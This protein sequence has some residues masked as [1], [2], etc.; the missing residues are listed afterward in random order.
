MPG[1]GEHECGRGVAGAAGQ[2][3]PG[4]QH[5][6]LR[7]LEVAERRGLRGVEQLAGPVGRG[8]GELGVRG[9][10]GAGAGADAVEIGLPFSDPMLDGPVIQQALEQAIARGA[11]TESLV[12]RR[13]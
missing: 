12:M 1:G 5:S 9:G 4:V 6:G 13:G 11:S 3:E 2:R 10:E 7:A 8:G